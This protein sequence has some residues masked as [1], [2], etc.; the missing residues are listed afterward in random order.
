MSITSDLKD[1]VTALTA[2]VTDL[3]TKVTA[4][5]AAIQAEIAALQAAIAG[6]NPAEIQ[7]A[8]DNIKT[9][10]SSVGAAAAAVAKETSDLTASLP[11]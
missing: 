1:A 2:A 7:T 5:D 4:N 3:T 6:G 10:S 11:A 8:I 9:L